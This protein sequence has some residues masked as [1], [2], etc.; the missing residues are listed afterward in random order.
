MTTVGIATGAGRG[1]GLA[2][3]QRLADTVDAL[4][5][6]DVDEASATAAAK[7]LAAAHLPG[8][9]EPW[10]APARGVKLA[11][12]HGWRPSLEVPDGT[13]RSLRVWADRR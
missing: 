13:H 2:C 12:A 3:A 10:P 11:D 1:V 9:D 5:L 6:V 8:R 4:L 7:E